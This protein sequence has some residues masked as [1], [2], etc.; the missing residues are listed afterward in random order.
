MLGILAA[1]IPNFLYFGKILAW[2]SIWRQHNSAWFHPGTSNKYILN[3]AQWES[4]VKYKN[5]LTV[6]V[7]QRL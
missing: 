3:A 2:K 7:T 5:R 1:D 4:F 6:T